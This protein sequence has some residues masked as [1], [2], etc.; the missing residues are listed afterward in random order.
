M[1]KWEGRYI[2]NI[3]VAPKININYVS[4]LLPLFSKS[5]LSKIVEFFITFD[6]N[7]Q[8][9]KNQQ[10]TAVLWHMPDTCLLIKLTHNS[11]VSLLKKNG[12][13]VT[14]LLPREMNNYQRH[15]KSY[16]RK[17][18]YQLIKVFNIYEKWVVKPI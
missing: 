11:L 3:K 1:I 8:Q 16:H 17:Q 18:L 9:S 4:K 5:R 7:I 6:P 10:I 2:K 15:C 13:S 12:S 14:H